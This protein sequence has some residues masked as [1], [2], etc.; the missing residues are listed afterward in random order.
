MVASPEGIPYGCPMQAVRA[1]I[2]DLDGT[3][4]DSLDDISDA[5]TR[6]LADAGLPG[7]DRDAVR[8]WIGGGARNLVAQ[9]APAA[10]VDEVHAAF[11]RH[12]DAA[13]AARTALYPGI[14]DALDEL[15]RRG[16]TLAV[17]SN[18]PHDLTVRI[19]G[20]LLGDWPF[21]VV[22][23]H[24]PGF[25]LKPSPEAA[26][27]V[28]HELGIAPAACALVGDAGTDVAT[29]RGAGMGAVAVT[30]GY[31]PRHELVETGAIVVDAPDELVSALTQ[32]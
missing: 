2:F 10:R 16:T 3:L 27:A 18:K 5:L 11:R 9:A 13:P 7:I 29:A 22:A 25:P 31:R 19:A 12:Y 6:A 4:V 1:V 21:A 26:L 28:S 24:R 15:A 14:G 30:W 20:A 32:R 23:G 8:G 17:L